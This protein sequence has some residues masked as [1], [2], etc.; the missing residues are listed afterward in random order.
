M[1]PSSLT[2]ISLSCQIHMDGTVSP[3]R[4]VPVMWSDFPETFRE[5]LLN[6]LWSPNITD[7]SME[8]IGGFPLSIFNPCTRLKRLSFFQVECASS[9]SDA[10]FPPQLDSLVLSR[11][12]DLTTIVSWASTGHNL[13]FLSFGLAD[14]ANTIVGF[15]QLTGL[16][17][18]FCDTLN[19]LDLASV[20]LCRFSFHARLFITNH[21]H[22]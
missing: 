19:E 8:R 9:T 20:P 13:R 21:L 18:A 15:G 11:I 17:D 16:L 7:V 14:R 1:L 6:C 4:I 10:Q 5:A 12:E 3:S 2:G 22:K